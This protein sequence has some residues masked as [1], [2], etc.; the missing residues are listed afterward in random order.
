MATLL[1]PVDFSSCAPLL[2][3]EATRFARAFDAGIL[4]V[5]VCEPPR[6]VPAEARVIEPGS[7]TVLTVRALLQRDAEAHLAPLLTWLKR[8]G[9]PAEATVRWGRVADQVL[10]AARER[11]ARMIV[12]GTHGRTGVA[13]VTLGSI[14]E[15]VVRHA[16][17]PVVTIRTKHRPDCAAAS[18][19]VCDQG[20]SSVEEALDAEAD[21]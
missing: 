11:G 14:A 13:R 2:L 17:V 18:C 10:E 15:D 8:V 5:H 1:V 3:E 19:A 20:R 4:L 16:E 12:M 9:V 6:G 7:D 21:G